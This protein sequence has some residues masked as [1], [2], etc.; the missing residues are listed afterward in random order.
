MISLYSDDIIKNITIKQKRQ[1]TNGFIFHPIKDESN[2]AIY[3]QT[4]SLFVPFGINNTSKENI[5]LSLINK[6]NDKTI[7]KFIDLLNKIDQLISF[8]FKN[9]KIN[10]IIKR[11]KIKLKI[12]HCLFFD[13]N[14]KKIESIPNN[15]YGIFIINFYGLWEL[16]DNI[17]IHL[18]LSQ[19]KLSIPSVL[20]EYSFIDN[21][22]KIPP[23]PPLP[24]FKLNKPHIKRNKEKSKKIKI[25]NNS[26]NP[27]SLND[28]KS[29]LNKLKQT[30]I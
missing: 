13:E 11:D 9:K 16:K 24:N 20:S 29:A 12:N 8:K 7:I 23:P 17:Y 2:K 10:P 21:K 27:P 19:A 15:V 5:I 1:H 22:K 26:Y 6:N 3:I 25:N 30:S 28:I 14:K 4:P 18:N